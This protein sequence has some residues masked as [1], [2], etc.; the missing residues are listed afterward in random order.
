MSAEE[1][2]VALESFEFADNAAEM[3][4]L[5][6]AIS[7]ANGEAAEWKRKHNALLGEDAKKQS[8]YETA[9]DEVR[10]EVASLQREK[11]LATY[12][13]QLISQGYDEALA[14]RGATAMA[15]GDMTSLVTIQKEFLEGYEK[16]L[17]ADVLKKTPT[18]PAGN[19]GNV[20]TK[21]DFLKLS[22]DKQMEFI[23]DNPNWMSEL[24]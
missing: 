24:K 7:K 18:P 23:K 6:A 19:G 8:E 10:K 22:T 17:K 1:K 15:D 13:A 9:L 3:E 12:N 20:V 2:L 5:K 16:K 11:T 4:K 21:A 14:L